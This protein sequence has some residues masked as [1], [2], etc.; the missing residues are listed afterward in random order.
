MSQPE[1]FGGW[2]DPSPPQGS[3]LPEAQ[4]PG[5][6]QPQGGTPAPV[7]GQPQYPSGAY[8]APPSAPGY[9]VPGYGVAYPHYG[10]LPPPPTNGMAVAALVVSIIGAVGLCGYGIGGLIGGVGAILG[11]VARR[12]IRERGEGGDGLALAGVIVGWIACGIAVAAIVVIVIFIV[13]IAA[14]A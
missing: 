5:V 1:P 2:P 10:Y 14:S 13:A 4:F 3:G 7:P 8:T 6:G 9:S 11:H 12:Q